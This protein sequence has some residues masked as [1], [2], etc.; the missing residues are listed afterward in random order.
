VRAVWIGME[1]VGWFV[2]VPLALAALLTGLVMSV[3]TQW[4]LFRHYWVL[5]S[6]VLTIFSTIVLLLHMPTV[7][8]MA[9]MAREADGAHRSGLGG[10]L[11][12]AG[13]GL[14]V[15]LVITVLNVYKPRG[16]TPYGWRKQHEQQKQ[17]TVS[18]AVDATDRAP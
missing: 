15:L 6:F 17:R 8:A 1:L 9:G 7:S 16:L 14:L 3:G 11:F 18:P 5:I 10:D 4:G 12:H 2:I 13:G